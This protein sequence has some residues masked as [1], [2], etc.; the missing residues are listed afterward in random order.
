MRSKA[1]QLNATVFALNGTENHVHLVVAIHPRRSIAEF[2]RQVK[3]VTSYRINQEKISPVRFSWQN[4][5]GVFSFDEKRLPNYVG[6]V[7][8]QKEHHAQQRLIPI[9]ERTE[10]P[11]PPLIRDATV[12]YYVEDTVWRDEMVML[13]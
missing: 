2:I 1:I 5:Y 9:L 7:E 10:E 4:E 3:G 12:G 11:T 8:R 13:G 6:Y